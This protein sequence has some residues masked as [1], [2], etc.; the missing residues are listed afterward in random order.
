MR[1]LRLLLLEFLVATAATASAAPVDP[2]Q[3]VPYVKLTH[4]EWSKSATIYQLNTRQF[5]A[6]GTFRAAERE[7]PR[8][9]ALNVDIVWL[10]PVHPIGVKNRKGVLGSPYSVLDYRA[11]NPEFGTLVDLKHFV[12]TAHQLGMRVI[13]D[14]VANHT[15]WDNP[16]AAEH[17]DWYQHDWQ[18]RFRPT[19]WFDWTDIIN[20][21]YRSPGLRKYMT[22]ALKFWV[23]E[24][25]VDGYRCDVAG[26]VPLDFWNN[27]RRELDAIKPVFMLAEWESRDLHAEAFDMTYAWSWY[28]A[29]TKIAKGHAD[30]GALAGY[31]SWNEGFFPPDI[32]R[33]TFTSNHDKNA[34]EG[35]A[36][37]QF[38]DAFAVATVLSVVGEG[39]PLIYGSQ[40][41]GESKRLKFF[42]KDPIE[43]RP[44]PNAELYRKLFA[45]KHANT[46]LWNAHW[47]A[48]MIQVVNTSPAAVLS[49]VRQN[50]RDKVFAVLNFSKEAKAVSFE[51]AGLWQ[52]TYTDYFTGERTELAA[53]AQVSLEPWGYRVFVRE[54]P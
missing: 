21:D 29:L 22:E 8:I 25:G 49:F 2:Y 33:M 11:V 30:A 12:A 42:E 32:M 48:R 27:V 17:P 53:A 34:W 4:P 15:A 35:T 20:L 37:E 51:E 13:L 47:G 9:K 18:G 50:D 14:W 26:F 43:W 46:A 5:T 10:M 36:P 39:L 45:L 41:A 7:L 40:E 52:G 44:H 1:S 23:R 19:P 6:E 38:G 54:K 3:P 31:Y 24:A 16:L 28:E